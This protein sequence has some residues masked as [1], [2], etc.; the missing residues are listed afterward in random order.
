MAR[1]R[2]IKPSFFTN[3][4]LAEIDPLGRLLF[5]GLWCHADREGR[6]EDRP[7]KLKAEILPYDDCDVESL[8]SD[9][10]RHGFITR[11]AVDGR[12]FIQVVNFSKHQNPHIKEAASEIPPQGEHQESTVQVQ[13]NTGTSPADS[14]NPHPDSLI[15]HP[16]IPL[17]SG[18]PPVS[19]Y[20]PEFIAVWQAYP[21][22]DGASKKDSFKAWSARVKAG[23]D[24]ATIAKAVDRYAAYVKAVGTEP[25]YIKRP[26]TFFGP[27]EH[28]ETDWTPPASK[29]PKVYHDISEMDYT[30]GVD[31]DGRF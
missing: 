13:C 4:A 25:R 15:P 28:Y 8:L 10:D 18:K 20:P 22:R 14:L 27:G 3:D 7:R 31:A 12:R 26:E 29:A 19:D 17:A 23:V 30:K 11:Y 16:S 6:M 2:N 5:Q 1:A 24:P 21:R 9:L